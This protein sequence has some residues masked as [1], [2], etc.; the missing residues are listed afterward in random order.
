[1]I[2]LLRTKHK[3]H[4]VLY[5]VQYVFF[6]SDQLTGSHDGP[7]SCNY[8]VRP[9]RHKTLF[10]LCRVRVLHGS[11]RLM[12]ATIAV[13]LSSGEAG[14]DVSASPGLAAYSLG[15]KYLN[16]DCEIIFTLD[17]LG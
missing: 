6:W 12:L 7:G 3:K 2:K 10:S 17:R 5:L 15:L 4:N 8:L 14:T 1:M 16:V 11:Q 9:L 13:K